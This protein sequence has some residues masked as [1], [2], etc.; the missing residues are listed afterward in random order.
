MGLADHAK[1]I[2]SDMAHVFAYYSPMGG[3]R[4]TTTS[5]RLAGQICCSCKNF[6]PPPHTPGERWCERCKPPVKVVYMSFERMEGWRVV[7][8]D[9]TTQQRLRVMNFMDEDKLVE[10]ARR[11]GAVTNLES[12][13][14]IERGISEG[15]GGV[16]L[17]L[18]LEQYD[19]LK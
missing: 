4:G 15:K 2:H 5:K 8:F 19:K 9:S 13:Q 14:A 10:L 16:F 1:S 12:K 11:G 7:F 18:S 17:K 6:L 3:E